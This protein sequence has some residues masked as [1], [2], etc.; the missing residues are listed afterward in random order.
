MN[1]IEIPLNTTIITNHLILHL[2]VIWTHNLYNPLHII[3]ICMG[4]QTMFSPQVSWQGLEFQSY[5]QCNDKFYEQ[6]G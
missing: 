6:C 5:N 1:S 3:Y 2:L 4:P